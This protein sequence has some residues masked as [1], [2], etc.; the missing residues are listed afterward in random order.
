MESMEKYNAISGPEA[1]EIIV[2]IIK[3]SDF[4]RLG[5]N[6][7]KYPYVVPL[8]HVYFQGGLILHGSFAGKKVE[9]IKRNE[10]ACYEIDYSIG[11]SNSITKTCH[12]EFKSAILYGEICQVKSVEERREYLRTMAAEYGMPFKHGSEEKCNIL[13]FKIQ[14]ASGREGRF[15]SHEERVLYHYDFAE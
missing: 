2:A 11:D 7:E 5:L 4:G 6:D 15:L 8:N 14:S 13:F 3:G 10:F 9:L 1:K 12:H